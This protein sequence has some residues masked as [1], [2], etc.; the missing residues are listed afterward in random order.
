MCTIRLCLPKS[1]LSR[2]IFQIFFLP[3]WNISYSAQ[4]VYFR[5]ISE[6]PNL[7]WTLIRNSYKIYQNVLYLL[8]VPMIHHRCLPCPS[9]NVLPSFRLSVISE[10]YIRSYPPLTNRT[11]FQSS[12]FATGLAI[13]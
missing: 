9:R 3:S 10:H 2:Y 13:S 5:N 11:L 6:V 12:C 4:R 8:N 7:P 1:R